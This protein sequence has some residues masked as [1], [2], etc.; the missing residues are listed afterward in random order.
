MLII[1]LIYH[2]C[3]EN[4]FQNAV[5]GDISSPVNSSITMCDSDADYNQEQLGDMDSRG[6]LSSSKADALKFTMTSPESSHAVVVSDGIERF[7]E[8]DENRKR[9]GAIG[10]IGND[11]NERDDILHE[12]RTVCISPDI[13]IDCTA[14]VE[15]SIKPHSLN[16]LNNAVKSIPSGL[17][18]RFLSCV[19]P[20]SIL[21]HNCTTSIP[22]PM[23]EENHIRFHSSSLPSYHISV[24][25]PVTLPI[26]ILAQKST[27]NSQNPIHLSEDITIKNKEKD[28]HK[29][30]E[31]E[32]NFYI[33]RKKKEDEEKKLEEERL[34]ELK[35]LTKSD[36][37]RD[38]KRRHANNH[39]LKKIAAAAAAVEGAILCNDICNMRIH[40]DM[41]RCM[42]IN[43]HADTIVFEYLCICIFITAAAA[44]QGT[45]P[46]LNF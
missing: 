15:S 17:S 14:A 1:S 36:Q 32:E 8:F 7:V 30:R 16:N 45:R 26:S 42:R 19:T 40:I 35:N 21:T 27:V 37:T 39:K 6:V 31:R 29:M 11:I 33:E 24:P 44:A 41:Y 38:K 10:I 23:I 25:V 3:L 9:T 13:P 5:R 4:Y 12:E 22:P 46:P 20:T 2:R 34:C 18:K 43:V 28:R